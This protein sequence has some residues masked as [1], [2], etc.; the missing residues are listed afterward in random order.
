MQEYGMTKML[1]IEQRMNGRQRLY[2]KLIKLLENGDVG[3]LMGGRNAAAL[4]SF[5]VG[6]LLLS[7]LLLL[8]LYRGERVGRTGRDH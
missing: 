2:F 5:N 7:S 8:F 6:L 1:V 4:L 3:Y